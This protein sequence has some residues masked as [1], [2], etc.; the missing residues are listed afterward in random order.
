M[1][2]ARAA[3]SGRGYLL[4]FLA[5]VLWGL[6]GLVAKVALDAGLE[7][8]EISF[9]RALLSGSAFVAHAAVRRKLR[10]KRGRD[11]AALIAFALVGVTLFYPA[12]TFA[13]DAGG[14]SLA[15]IL[16]Y[17]APAFVA[18]LAFL[19][20]KEPLTPGKVVLVIVATAGIILV[21]LSGGDGVNVTALSV[22]WGLTAGLAY[23]SYYLFGK[24]ALARYDPVT[25]YAF[26]QP[27]G[28]LCLL[29]F[30]RFHAW[31]P[32]AA[33]ALVLMAVFS[34][35]IAYLAYYNGLRHVE[36]SRA[37]LVATVE[38]VVGTAVAAALY[39][40]RL[41]AW[42]FFGGGLVLVAALLSAMPG[43]ARGRAG[44]AVASQAPMFVAAVVSEQGEPPPLDH[45]AVR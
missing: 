39:G 43:R 35:Y 33:L 22:T 8:L 21:A 30:V 2:T 10:L 19:L 32:T 42:G 37:V 20:L 31:T 45:P 4:V 5:A 7:P 1:N 38:P 27:I 13:I 25:I 9:W 44:Q 41:G 12:L 23:S 40:E 28:A 14:I 11:L 3:G 17:S 34:T 36:A 15:V 26:I 29:P 16:L 18:V 24:W 6:I